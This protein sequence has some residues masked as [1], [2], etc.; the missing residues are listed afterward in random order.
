MCNSDRQQTDGFIVHYDSPDK[1]TIAEG[2]EDSEVFPEPTS[3]GFN[4][5][6]QE[7]E[8]GQ[9]VNVASPFT[10]SSSSAPNQGNVATPGHSSGTS[11]SGPHKFRTLADLFDSTEEVH[12][13]EYSGVCML[14]VEEPN[15]VQQ[16]LEQTCWRKA[17]EEEMDSIHQNETWELSDL[18]SN[19]KD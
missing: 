2:S 19:H 5:P 12:D 4:S 17:M 15:S 3:A 6:S 1:I 7:S 18:P 16:A 10:P 13:F 11:T 8:T 14:A 9:N